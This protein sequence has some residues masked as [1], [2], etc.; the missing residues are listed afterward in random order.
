MEECS[1]TLVGVHVVFVADAKAD[2]VTENY[3]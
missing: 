1:D 3:E 2:R